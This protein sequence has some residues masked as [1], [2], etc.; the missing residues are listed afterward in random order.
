MKDSHLAELRGGQRSD[1]D[2]ALALQFAPML[3]MDAN[4]PLVPIALGYTVFREDRDSPSFPRRIELPPACEFAIEY[5]IWWDW[6]IEHLYELEHVWVYVA[7]TTGSS[8]PRPAG[9]ASG[10]PCARR[11]V[12]CLIWTVGFPPVPNPANTPSRPIR[13]HY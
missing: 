11:M 2:R 7:G 3:R 12:V 1:N 9:T 5:A 4:E 10:I 13:R 8:L 6:D